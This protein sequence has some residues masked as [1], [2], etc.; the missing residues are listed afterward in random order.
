AGPLRV[1]EAL[2]HPQPAAVVEGHGDRLDDVRLAGEERDAEPGRHGHRLRC[3]LRGDRPL[4]RFLEV[5][6]VRRGGPGGAEQQ[7]GE[8][9]EVLDHHRASAGWGRARIP[10]WYPL[11][12]CE[13]NK[14]PGGSAV[15]PTILSDD[16]V[17]QY[18]EDGYY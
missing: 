1:A 5:G 11:S 8:R 17:R 14:T 16:A 15:P 2:D 6:E 9:Q 13:S 10:V 7:R 18:H 12:G 4:V 3:V